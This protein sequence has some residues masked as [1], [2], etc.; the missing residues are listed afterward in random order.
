MR[1]T[2]STGS[3]WKVGRQ[4]IAWQPKVKLHRKVGGTSLVDGSNDISGLVVGL[5]IIGALALPAMFELLLNVVAS[6]FV[7]PFRVIGAASTT[8]HVRCVEKLVDDS[9][10]SKKQFQS[11]GALEHWSVPAT[12]FIRAGKLR[13]ALIEL[14]KENG[15]SSD[16]RGFAD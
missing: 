5:L 1:F 8:V 15:R 7:L 2:D 9:A 12:G 14:I 3:T 16:V 11:D 13:D 4:W 10:P 6:A